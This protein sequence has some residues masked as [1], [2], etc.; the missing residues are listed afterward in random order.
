MF[1]QV[2]VRPHRRTYLDLGGGGVTYLGYLDQGGTFLGWGVPTL[3]GGG[4]LPWRGGGTYLG[5]GGVSTLA[6]AAYGVL[7]T[8]WAVCLLRSHRRTVL[9]NLTLELFLWDGGI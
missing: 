8:W 2:C 5:R 7:A 4:Y 3:D 1:S 9:F 6:R